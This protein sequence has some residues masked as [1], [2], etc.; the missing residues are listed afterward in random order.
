MR[1]ALKITVVV[2]FN[3]LL[4]FLLAECFSLAWFGVSHGQFFYSERPSLPSSVEA[5]KGELTSFQ[6]HPYYGVSRRPGTRGGRGSRNNNF[7]FASTI[8][9]PF[10]KTS[11]NQY[12]I[13]IFGGSVAERFCRHGGPLVCRALKKL[14]RFRDR[15]LVLLNLGRGG[16]KQPQQIMV[17]SYFLSIGQDFDLV[18]NIDGF[19]EV[20]LAGKNEQRGIDGSMPSYGHLESL[21]N[22]VDSDTL[23][24][25][26]LGRMHVAAGYKQAAA[27]ARER[28]ASARSAFVGLI[29]YLSHGHAYAKYRDELVRLDDT[30]SEHLDESLVFMKETHRKKTD[31]EIIG[32]VVEIWA[33]SSLVMN[34]ICEGNGIEYYQFIQPNQYFSK[35]NFT[36]RELDEAVNT[37]LKYARFVQ[38]GYPQLLE[39][40]PSIRS[41]GVNLFSA[42]QIFDGEASTVYIDR[43][44]HFNNLGNRLLANYIAEKI[45]EDQS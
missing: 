39:K 5:G 28:Y 43:C 35:K 6:I 8:D 13:G 45:S 9:F 3:I 4:F 14:D 42:V 15:E 16:F 40:L 23:T 12:I 24:F 26:R 11:E 27:A 2:L 10:F 31:S 18:I 41:A 25:E 32:K 22:L 21:I 29:H 36:A 1:K 19:N 34:S 30:V 38:A 17:L 37:K 33:R 44:C 7:G 20:V